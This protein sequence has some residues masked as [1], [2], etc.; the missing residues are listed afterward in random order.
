MK[1]KILITTLVVLLTLSIAASI[2]VFAVVR[3]TDTD[4][5]ATEPESNVIPSEKNVEA[6]EYVR[7]EAV[8]VKNIKLPGGDVLELEYKS[9]RN[10]S[11]D[12]YTDIYT[13]GDGYEYRFNEKNALTMANISSAVYVDAVRALKNKDAEVD[14]AEK[15]EEAARKHVKA[16]FGDEIDGYS[17]VYTRFDDMSKEYFF[18]F[19]PTYGEGGFIVGNECHVSVFADGTLVSCSMA[20]KKDFEDFDASVLDGVDKSALFANCDRLIKTLYGDKMESYEI[21]KVRLV[22]TDGVY[23]LLVTAD[24]SIEDYII[25][26]AFYCEID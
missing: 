1:T 26:E 10:N 15:A 13:D 24:I 22:M 18:T 20:N 12:T 6:G 21:S 23:R 9:T 25:A 3:P 16:V 7:K 5:E 19:A 2:T 17:T 14:T 8:A 4:L 11:L